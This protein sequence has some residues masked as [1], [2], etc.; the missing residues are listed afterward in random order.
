MDFDR[1]ETY[2]R[3]R[4][5]DRQLTMLNGLLQAVRSSNPFWEKRLSEYGIPSAPLTSVNQLQDFPLLSKSDVVDDQLQYPPYGT[6]LTY[7]VSSYARIHQ[8]SGTTGKPLRWL[9]TPAS[10]NWVM[11]CWEQMYRLIGI[12]PEDI[13]AFP[14]SFGPFIGFWGACGGAQRIGNLTLTMGGM[15][16]ESRLQMM[17]DLSA[18]I[19]CCTPTYALRMADVARAEGIDLANSAAR[20]LLLAGEPGAAVP[21]VR[22]RIEQDW[23]ARVIDQWGMTDIGC[24]GIEAIDTPRELTILESQCIAEIV[25]QETLRP[26]SS[27]ELGE[28]V[29]TNVGRWGQPVIRYRT[30]DLVRA[31]TTPAPSGNSM[32]RLDGGILG[33]TDDMVTIRGNNVFPSTIDAILREFQD[34]AEYRATV[35]TKHSMPHLKIEIES[36]NTVSENGDELNRLIQKIERLIKVRLN[37]HAEIVSVCNL[38]RFELKGRRFFRES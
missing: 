26:V 28:L 27:G 17:R 33:R 11:E 7:P 34:V 31:A 30:G 19:I 14:F 8:S 1:P 9:D 13:F 2:D 5:Q 18:T 38:P 15:S 4:L 22:S 20:I 6:N 16:T 3:T 29:I 23:G 12:R 37:F 32:L 36:S 21:A 10:W 25:D 35:I 24:L